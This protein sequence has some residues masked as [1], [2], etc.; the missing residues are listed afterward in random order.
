[1]RVAALVTLT[2]ILNLQ[3]LEDDEEGDD[4]KK[5]TMALLILIVLVSTMAVVTAAGP[6]PR[7]EWRIFGNDKTNSTDHFLGTTDNQP[8]VIKTNNTTAMTIST[9]QDVAFENHIDVDG[10]ISVS[11][12][13]DGV[14]VSAHAVEV[15]AHHSRYTDAEAAATGHERYT[16]AEAE[17]AVD[18]AA[19]TADMD[20][21]HTRYTDAEAAAAGHIRYTDAEAVAAGHD[22]YTDV[23]AVASMG[24]KEDSN[25]LNH[26][27]YIAD[28]EPNVLI[29]RGCRLGG[30]HLT[31]ADLSGAILTGARVGSATGADF[32]GADLRFAYL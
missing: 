24:T 26:D 19:H 1:V 29:C 31:S 2:V 27:R 22:R 9:G 4:M 8:L 14:D 6:K 15:D 5:I 12:A 3:R 23:E 21:H 20:A 25:P 28:P 16:D 10:D 13:V 17:A 32:S 7:S 30:E 11:G 18:I